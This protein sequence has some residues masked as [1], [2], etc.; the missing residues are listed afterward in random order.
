MTGLW[1]PYVNQSLGVDHK[2]NSV[3]LDEQIS[4]REKMTVEDDSEPLLSLFLKP[5][6]RNRSLREDTP[7][8]T[9]EEVEQKFTLVKRKPKDMG[10][11][12]KSA[13]SSHVEEILGFVFC[14]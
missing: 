9:S 10:T 2:K 7:E 8:R 4:V 11:V 6:P 13:M 12:C 3:S 5:G 14:G 1:H